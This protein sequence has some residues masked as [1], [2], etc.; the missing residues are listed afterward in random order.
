MTS[1]IES[2]LSIGK[3]AGEIV[4]KTQAEAKSFEAKADAEIVSLRKDLEAKTEARIE[5]F[6]Q[7]AQSRYD[8]DVV[9]A[10][11]DAKTALASLDRIG[12][13]DVSKQASRIVARFRE[14]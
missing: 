2:I 13:N 9:K 6:R 10:Q 4:E 11:D 8:Q 3:Q 1:L 12:P 7:E 14:F 5:A